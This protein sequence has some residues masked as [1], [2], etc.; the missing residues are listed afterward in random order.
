MIA[1]ATGLENRTSGPTGQVILLGHP[2]ACT[3]GL[4]DRN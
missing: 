1:P 3:G 4:Y 2:S